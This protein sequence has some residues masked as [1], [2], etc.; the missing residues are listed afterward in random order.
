MLW[1]KFGKSYKDSTDGDSSNLHNELG[2]DSCV[3]SYSILCIAKMVIH[4]TCYVASSSPII[5]LSPSPSKI[6]FIIMSVNNTLYQCC[7]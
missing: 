3:C 4:V 1:N 5:S 6:S 7:Y 2:K